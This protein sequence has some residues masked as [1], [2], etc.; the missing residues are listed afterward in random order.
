MVSKRELIKSLCVR[1]ITIEDLDKAAG[2]GFE[3]GER[4]ASEITGV[5][6]TAHINHA[7]GKVKGSSKGFDDLGFA[8]AWLAFEGEHGLGGR[9]IQQTTWLV[10]DVASTHLF[11]VV[12]PTNL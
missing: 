7:E 6:D 8:H 5:V 1:H 9:R 11:S 4:T 10:R 3:V 2:I 12:L